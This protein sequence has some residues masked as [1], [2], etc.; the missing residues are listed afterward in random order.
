MLARAQAKGQMK[1][2]NDQPAYGQE[3][4]RAKRWVEVS[5][6][7]EPERTLP[8]APV[9]RRPEKAPALPGL[10]LWLRRDA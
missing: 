6:N 9:E 7:A 1:K 2:I 10:D 8:I 5:L 4:L 3:M